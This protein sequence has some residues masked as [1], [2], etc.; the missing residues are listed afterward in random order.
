M[1]SDGETRRLAAIMATDIVA[2][3]RLMAADESGTLAALKTLRK[4]L[5]YPKIEEY[6]GRVVKLVATAF[7]EGFDLDFGRLFGCA[8][9]RVT[10]MT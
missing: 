5:W 7:G 6:G 4:E 8:W 3:S 10:V 9:L 1:A 2:Y